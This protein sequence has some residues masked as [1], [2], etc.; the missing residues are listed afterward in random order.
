MSPNQPNELVALP[1]T[2]EGHKDFNA[3]CEKRSRMVH[4]HT[5]RKPGQRLSFSGTQTGYKVGANLS[6]R[7]VSE[8]SHAEKR[9]ERK[10]RWKAARNP[11][12]QN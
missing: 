1:D 9:Q 4:M 2:S 5:A 8:P 11:Q 12:P 3:A 6:L 10:A 7:K